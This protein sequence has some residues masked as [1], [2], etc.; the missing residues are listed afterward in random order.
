MN[1]GA[2]ADEHLQREA[3]F[4]P[5]H[6][7]GFILNR[8]QFQIG[9][10]ASRNLCPCEG[11]RREEALVLF[12]RHRRK[13]TTGRVTFIPASDPVGFWLLLGLSGLDTA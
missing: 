6:R 8:S 10:F 11:Q 7:Y 3:R 9:G 4:Q 2:L 12:V 1:L 13:H 5:T